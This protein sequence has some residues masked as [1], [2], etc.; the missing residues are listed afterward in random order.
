MIITKPGIAFNQDEIML[1]N[2]HF[3]IRERLPD[4]SYRKPQ[5]IQVVP[6]T[7]LDGELLS[8]TYIVPYLEEGGGNFH[9]LYIYEKASDTVIAPLGSYKLFFAFL[10]EV[11]PL[12]ESYKQALLLHKEKVNHK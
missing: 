2:L 9:K 3:G 10:K 5:P 8:P 6:Q 4:G 12:A 7:S 11:L 1:F